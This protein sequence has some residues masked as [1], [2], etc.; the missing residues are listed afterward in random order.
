MI[1]EIFLPEKIGSQRIIAQR[2]VGLSLHENAVRLALIHAKRHKTIVETLKEE[3]LENGTE[4]TYADRAALAIKKLLASTKDYHYIRVCIPASIVVFKELQLQFSD[5]EKIRM[6]LDYEIETMLPFSIDEAI[7]DFIITKSQKNQSAQVLVAAIRSQDLQ[8]H[9]AIYEKAEINPAH[10]TIDLFALYGL[11]QQIPE[12]Y[13]LPNATALV[14]VGQDTT[15]IA[16]V[17]NGQLRLTRYIQRGLTTVFGHIA[18]ETGMSIENIASKLHGQSFSNIGDE[19]LVRALQKHLVLLLNEIQFTLNSF[20]LK[21]NFY[22]AVNKIIFTGNIPDIANLMT[23]CS[24]TLQIPCEIFDC[25]KLFLISN[26]KNKVRDRIPHWGDFAVTLGTAMP[27][28]EQNAFDLRRKQFAF[29]RHSLLVRQLGTIFIIVLIMFSVIGIKG[30][31]DISKLSTEA[32]NFELR[33]INR[34][35]AENIFTRDQFPK[36]PTLAGVIRESEKVIQGKLELWAPFAQQRMRPLELWLEL[37]RIINKRQFDV[38]IKDL[39]CTTQEKGWEK[40]KDGSTR[41]DAGLP[42]IEVEGLFK[43]K[44]GDHF[45]DF[46]LL[47]NRFKDSLLLKIIEPIDASPAPDGGV[48]FVVRMRMKDK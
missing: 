9:L 47:E 20:S 40:E 23:F 42:K 21:L 3:L 22:E 16:F 31:L 27:S 33:E 17:Q 28:V 18:E 48:N 37:T 25:Q 39:I 35:K 13:S 12:Y 29:Q 30:Y 6:V 34:I 26:V 43:S 44:T 14:E 38:T 10:V 36:K 5:P 45:V 19:T 11:Y 24:D 32:K 46:T 1:K 8:T 4:D 7:V 2:I 41:K 15:R